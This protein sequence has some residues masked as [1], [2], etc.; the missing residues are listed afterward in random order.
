MSRKK[1]KRKLAPRSKPKPRFKQEDIE[2]LGD[3]ELIADIYESPYM[4]S[5]PFAKLGLYSLL[6]DNKLK[7][8]GRK[9]LPIKA[10]YDDRIWTLIDRKSSKPERHVFQGQYNKPNSLSFTPQSQRFVLASYDKEGKIEPLLPD[11]ILINTVPDFQKSVIPKLDKIKKKPSGT[12][13][14][15]DVV[16]DTIIHELMHRGFLNTPALPDVPNKSQHRYIDEKQKVAYS[17]DYINNIHRE[18][19]EKELQKDKQTAKFIRDRM[20]SLYAGLKEYEEDREPPDIMT[21]FFRWLNE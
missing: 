20:P 6:K 15:R 7:S 19:Y 8:R 14:T 17:P 11:Q 10:T 16:I 5:N 4:R 1:Q 12:T 2:E 3:T 18:Y 13:S 9:P 21:R